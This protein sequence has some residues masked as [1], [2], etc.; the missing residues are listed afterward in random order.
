MS[1]LKFNLW[2]KVKDNDYIEFNVKFLVNFTTVSTSSFCYKSLILKC[3]ADWLKYSE[4]LITFN[5]K[6][7]VKDYK[8]NSSN[9]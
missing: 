7:T 4:E 8:K 5:N 2:K 3:Y 1:S 6:L 9:I